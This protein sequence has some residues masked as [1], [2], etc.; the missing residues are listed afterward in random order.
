LRFN[1]Q[2]WSDYLIPATSIVPPSGNHF[3]KH[4]SL[5]VIYEGTVRSVVANRGFFFMS[6]PEQGQKDVF[7]HFSELEK[8]GCREPKVGERF[9][10][11]IRSTPK[12]PQ[13]EKLE[14]VV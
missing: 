11:E 6:P 8:A 7:C 13:A 4:W 3:I 5:L 12:G 1:Y 14:A 9:K 2:L 10:Y